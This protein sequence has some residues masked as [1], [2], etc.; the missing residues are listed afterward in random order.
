M[1]LRKLGGRSVP[2]DVPRRELR[3]PGLGQSRHRRAAGPQARTPP[4][5]F[6]EQP[7]QRGL[8]AAA[9][10][11]SGSTAAAPRLPA[12]RGTAIL[13]SPPEE[14]FPLQ[15]QPPGHVTLLGVRRAPDITAGEGAP[16]VC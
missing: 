12:A 14:R 15:E 4:S 7:F 13:P 10:A 9:R 1:K 3:V 2:G 16:C 5:G 11:G 6:P 8:A